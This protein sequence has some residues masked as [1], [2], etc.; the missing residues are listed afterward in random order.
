MADDEHDR[1]VANVGP[2]PDADQTVAHVLRGKQASIRQ[3]PLPPGSP[4]WDDLLTLPMVEVERRANNNE[5]G[6]RTVR[7]LLKDRRFEK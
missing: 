5:P 3:A 7:K 1:G 4:S 6:Y 2:Q